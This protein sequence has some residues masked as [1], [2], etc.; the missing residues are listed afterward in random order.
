MANKMVLLGLLWHTGNMKFLHLVCF[1]YTSDYRVFVCLYFLV[2]LLKGGCYRWSTLLQIHLHP[3][4]SRNSWVHA[5]P[6]ISRL[7]ILCVFVFYIAWNSAFGLKTIYSKLSFVHILF[8]SLRS[9]FQLFWC[10][11]S[12]RSYVS[13]FTVSY[14][15]HVMFPR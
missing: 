12:Q 9:F 6:T 1:E 10:I 13:P 3:C 8:V 5:Y 4:V 2:C 15:I 7:M 14:Y 11:R